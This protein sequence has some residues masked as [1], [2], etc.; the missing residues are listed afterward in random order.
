MGMFGVIVRLRKLELGSVV[1]GWPQV[2]IVHAAVAVTLGDL[3]CTIQNV[4]IFALVAAG[5]QFPVM[6]VR[7]WDDFPWLRIS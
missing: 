7:A 5:A 6:I 2:V 3:L 4:C 1:V